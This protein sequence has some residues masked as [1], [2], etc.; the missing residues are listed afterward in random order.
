MSDVIAVSTSPPRTYPVPAGVVAE[1]MQG[2]RWTHAYDV[3]VPDA[4]QSAASL[5]AS[6]PNLTA[7][8]IDELALL[9]DTAVHDGTT[10]GGWIAGAG[11]YPSL[12]RILA[13]L[14]G[15]ESLKGWSESVLASLE[16]SLAA[17]HDAL[18][19]SVGY[20]PD[21]FEYRGLCTNGD[22]DVVTHLARVADGSWQHWDPS[23]AGWRDVDASLL[24]S[25]PMVDPDA[26]LLAAII[27]AVSSGDSLMMV[28]GTPMSFLPP[29][30]PVSTLGDDVESTLV[31]AVVDDIDT[32]AVWSL[33]RLE[34]GRS[35]AVRAAGT[36]ETVDYWP[37]G[38]DLVYLTDE[39][40]R[41]QVISDVD[42]ADPGISA[43]GAGPR[44]FTEDEMRAWASLDDPPPATPVLVHPDGTVSALDT[45]FANV[46]AGIEAAGPYRDDD[47]E[48]DDDERGRTRSLVADAE[49]LR[50]WAVLR[51]RRDALTSA[52]GV[53]GDSVTPLVA[54]ALGG[55][56]RNR[57]GARR[58]RRY[59]TRGKGALKIRWGT[60]GDW[61]RCYRQ[62]FKHMGPRAAGYCQLRHKE[63]TGMYTGNKAHRR[64][65]STIKAATETPCP[66]GQHRMPDGTCM[67]DEQMTASIDALT[68]SH[69]GSSGMVAL[70]PRET[71][72][73]RLVV[74]GGEPADKM[75]LTLCFLG[76]VADWSVEQMS[77]VQSTMSSVVDDA[78]VPDLDD[79]SGIFT[80]AFGVA[81]WNPGD[82]A[83]WVYSI[84]G[85]VEIPWIYDIVKESLEQIGELPIPA[86]HVPFIPHV[87]AAYG[88]DT[89]GLK[90]LTSR[91]GTVV[92]DRLRVSFGNEV[93]D[94][95]LDYL[96]DGS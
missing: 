5:L 48:D 59:W 2:V 76:P 57:G 38:A 96:K 81:L 80:E 72:T 14:A 15:G 28:Y 62:L 21:K 83:V 53:D 29:G 35:M 82:E 12:S 90:E 75:H 89:I 23:T 17:E 77:A 93:V 44:Y 87:T 11:N 46:I 8:Q 9:F 43:S 30:A 18:L 63:M 52:I 34:P 65:V 58:L 79:S 91:L 40:L 51:A 50:E 41:A 94:Y 66:P 60:H 6:S 49:T 16:R 19:A 33:V 42:A 24:S 25:C 20:D 61:R 54:R 39:N 71:D 86:Q 67:P 1:V 56:D 4:Y 32:T 55:L 69:D 7:E 10:E 27:D 70:V 31:A 26:S 47:D 37:S 85:S 74:P 36:W 68:A 3:D 45:M 78:V 22:P 88:Q 64:G 92:F 13:S 73:E 84:G 95:R